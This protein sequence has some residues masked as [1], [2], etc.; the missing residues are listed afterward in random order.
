MP[1]YS[2]KLTFAERHIQRRWVL[3]LECF[4]DTKLPRISEALLGMGPTFR[5][6]VGTQVTLAL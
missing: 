5:T 3:G 6:E 1:E 2:N 4:T